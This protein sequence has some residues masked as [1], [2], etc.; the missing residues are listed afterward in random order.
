MFPDSFAGNALVFLVGQAV[1]WGYLRTGLLTRGVPL[2]AVLWLAVDVALVA[3]FAYQETGP[4]YLAA[5]AVMQ[6]CAVVET[7]RFVAG[8]LNRRRERVKER[9]IERY[10]AAFTH[11]LRDELEQAE[12]LYRKLLRSDPWDLES[13]LGLATLLARTGARRRARSMFRRAR[14]LDRGQRYQDV[15]REELERC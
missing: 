9:R 12:R 1:A 15:I 8:R 2:M 3:R 11:Y 5:L 6:A 14:S 7:V 4:V 13:R 10:R